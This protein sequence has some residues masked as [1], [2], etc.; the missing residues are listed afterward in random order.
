MKFQPG[1]SG[2]P[3]GRPP[4]SRALTALLEKAGGRKISVLQPDGSIR[5]ISRKA[6]LADL[7]WSLAL[8]G[9]VTLP[10]GTR[11]NVTSAEE[12][13]A[14]WQFIYK[15]I[16]GPPRAELDITSGGQPLLILDDGNPDPPGA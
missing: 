4:K 9:Q 1:Q 12:L 10:D 14:V 2:N 11:V 8:T 16:D 5:L 7:L 6:L 3:N 15:H 13:F